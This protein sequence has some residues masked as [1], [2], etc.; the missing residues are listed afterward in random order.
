MFFRKYILW[1]VRPSGVLP[2]AMRSEGGLKREEERVL[3]PGVTIM[4][5]LICKF[6]PFLGARPTLKSLVLVP[7]FSRGPSQRQN[8]LEYGCTTRNDA[9]WLS[10]TTLPVTNKNQV[11]T[12]TSVQDLK[13]VMKV[14]GW[15]LTPSR[16]M[17]A[18]HTEAMARWGQRLEA[19][20]LAEWRWVSAVAVIART[21][22]TEKIHD[23]AAQFAREWGVGVVD[24]ADSTRKK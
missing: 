24:T 21:W 22:M 4:A 12:C 19:D 13:E 3:R 10:T 5:L 11:A 18:T 23:S 15:H 7:N 14:E 6:Q 1:V 20:P 8:G 2:F 16:T 17:W 9:G